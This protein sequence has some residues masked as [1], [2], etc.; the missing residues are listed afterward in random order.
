M[1]IYEA[2]KEV[3][4]MILNGETLDKAVAYAAEDNDVH[5]ALVARKFAEQYVSAEHVINAAAAVI[6]SR[7]AALKN[8]AERVARIHAECE[9]RNDLLSVMIR[10]GLVSVARNTGTI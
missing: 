5:P 10:S 7:A 1:S 8:E 9:G 2:V 4:E 3:R 6:Q